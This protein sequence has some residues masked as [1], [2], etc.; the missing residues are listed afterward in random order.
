MLRGIHKASSNWLG[1]AVMGV[2]LGLIGSASGSGASATFS[3]ASAPS[4]VAKV[5]GT[6]IPIETVPPALPGPAAAAQPPVRTGRS[7]PTRRARSASTGRCSSDIDRRDRARRAGPQAAARRQRRRDR[8]RRSPTSR[9][10]KGSTGQFDRSRFEQLH[11]QHAASPKARYRRRAA[12][13]HAAPAARS[14]RSAATRRCRRPR[15]RRSTASRTR[16]A[17][18]NTSSL[19]AAQAGDIA[20]PDARGARQVF[21]GAQGRC[22]ARR[23]TASSR[24]LSLTPEDL[25]ARIEVSDED[26]KDAYDDRRARYGTPERRHLAADRVSRTSKRPRP[27]SDKLAQGTTFEA[28]AAERGLKDTDIDL[29]TVAKAAI[30]DRDVADAA[31]ALKAGEVSAPVQGRFGIAIVK[32]DAIEAGKVRPFEEVAAEIKRDIAER[33]RQERDD[34]RPGQDRGRARRR[35]DAGRGRARSSG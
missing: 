21:R 8:A 13:H 2:V 19:G 17:A 23:N 11:P 22:S 14:A 24:S 7:R 34:Q 6:E 33:A 28:L 15:S 12:A 25:A 29:G 10:F 1:R 5:G 35:R 16:S 27:P 3:A 31:F 4:T 26:L 18:S 30:V 20:D 9:S 32:V